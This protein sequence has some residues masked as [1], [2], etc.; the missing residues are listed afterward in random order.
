MP[1]LLYFLLFIFVRFGLFSSSWKNLLITLLWLEFVVLVLY[2]SISP[3][4]KQVWLEAD[5]LPF[6]SVKD[7]KEWSYDSTPPYACIHTDNFIFTSN[8]YRIFIWTTI[9]DWF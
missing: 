3:N 5:F 2:F 7:K 6:P 4:I 9:T 8:K 1:I